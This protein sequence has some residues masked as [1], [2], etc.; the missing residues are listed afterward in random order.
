MRQ[1]IEKMIEDAE[2]RHHKAIEERIASLDRMQTMLAKSV[3]ELKKIRERIDRIENTPFASRA[4]LQRLENDF[5]R[6][7]E[8]LKEEIRKDVLAHKEAIAKT[9]LETAQIKDEVSQLK[10]AREEMKRMKAKD[11]MTQ[12]AS[13]DQKTRW[14]EAQLEQADIAGLRAR[15]DKLQAELTKFKS[16]APF[17][18]E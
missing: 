7:K 10:A 8:R 13:L 18:I 3:E 15:V 9:A 6:E 17:I 2:I 4:E 1:S 5:V 14:L 12:L 11:I 16:S